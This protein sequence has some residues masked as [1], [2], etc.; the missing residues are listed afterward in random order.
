[1]SDI[2]TPGVSTAGYIA[3]HASRLVIIP[4]AYPSQT[5]QAG[6]PY[7]RNARAP[8]KRGALFRRRGAGDRAG[9]ELHPALSCSVGVDWPSM[10]R[11]LL[12]IAL[13]AFA[14]SFVAMA[15]VMFSLM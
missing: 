14:I 8:G 3:D 4:R 5:N 1:M 7:Q 10:I 15:E 2:L 12:T 9:P 11:D 6:I 13:V